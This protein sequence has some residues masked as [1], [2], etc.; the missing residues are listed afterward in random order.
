MPPDEYQSTLKAQASG[1]LSLAMH[2]FFNTRVLS[3]CGND[4]S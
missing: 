2:Y 1:T 3:G 4:F